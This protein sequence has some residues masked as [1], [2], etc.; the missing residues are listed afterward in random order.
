VTGPRSWALTV[1]ASFA[2]RFCGDHGVLCGGPVDEL[3][4]AIG[5]RAAARR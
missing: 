2:S 5:S 3:G 4:H 1:D